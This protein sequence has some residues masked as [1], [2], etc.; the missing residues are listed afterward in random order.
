MTSYTITKD[1]ATD[2]ATAYLSGSDYMVNV[3]DGG[4]FNQG[5]S[6]AD[7]DAAVLDRWATVTAK[8]ATGVFEYT[9][10]EP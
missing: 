8:T 9:T 3:N 1:G 7:M 10:C 2:T 6:F 5:D 4:E